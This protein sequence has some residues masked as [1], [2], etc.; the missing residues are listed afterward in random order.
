MNVDS[1]MLIVLVWGVFLGLLIGNKNFR[2]KFFKGLRKFLAGLSQG[3]RSYS[4][5]YQGSKER[6]RIEQEPRHD[7]KHRYVETHHLVKC[8]NCIGTGKVKRAVPA[9][10]PENLVKNKT[11]ECSE[12]EGTGKV[13]D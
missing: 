12:C 1:T 7:V 11:E 5:Q 13:Y 6:K 10:M 3:A 9:M 8:E 2:A 4:A